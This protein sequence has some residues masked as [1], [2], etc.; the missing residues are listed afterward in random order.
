MPENQTQTSAVSIYVVV[1]AVIGLVVGIIAGSIFG[2]FIGGGRTVA[3]LSA[4]VAIIVDLFVRRNLSARVPNLFL[5]ALASK[6]PPSLLI[7][8]CITAIAGGLATN[9]IGQLMGV[10]SGAF[11]GGLSGLF[12]SLM[13]AILV[14]FREQEHY[15]QMG[16]TRR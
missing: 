15:E 10:Q 14:V 5:G 4:F 13:T 16:K 8:A 6:T 12:A 3:I 7:V 1:A 11:L 2:S 9:D